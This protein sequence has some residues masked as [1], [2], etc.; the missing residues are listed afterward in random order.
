MTLSNNCKLIW[1]IANLQ[2]SPSTQAKLTATIP[3]REWEK[4]RER[5]SDTRK[6]KICS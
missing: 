3:G 4:E 6:D 1:L 2:K 5:Q